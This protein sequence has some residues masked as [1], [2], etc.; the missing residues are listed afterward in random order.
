MTNDKWTD[1]DLLRDWAEW[2]NHF[3]RQCYGGTVLPPLK[4]TGDLL[5]CPICTGVDSI[6]TAGQ[7]CAACGRE[8]TE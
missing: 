5:S 3:G 4:R 8:L 6:H 1:R 2:W 7:R